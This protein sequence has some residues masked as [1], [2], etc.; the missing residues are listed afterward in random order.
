MVSADRHLV[1]G[2]CEAR[3]DPAEAPR[4]LNGRFGEGAADRAPHR[5]EPETIRS[6]PQSFA[7]TIIVAGV[8]HRVYPALL[9]PAFVPSHQLPTGGRN[10]HGPRSSA[11][12]VRLLCP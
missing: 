7:A 12:A 6:A 2:E 1:G 3:T 9:Q 4:H 10:Q 11:V 8:R 5:P